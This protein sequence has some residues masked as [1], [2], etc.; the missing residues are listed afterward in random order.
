MVRIL[1]RVGAGLFITD[2]VYCMHGGLIMPHLSARVTIR[3]TAQ[4]R[5]CDGRGFRF[6]FSVGFVV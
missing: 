6:R 5:P 4:I 3:L 2:G 1:N